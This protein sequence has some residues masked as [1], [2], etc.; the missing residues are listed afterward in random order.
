MYG[1][2][3]H[4]P[5]TNFSSTNA[6]GWNGV[7]GGSQDDGQFDMQA[8]IASFRSISTPSPWPS[9]PSHNAVPSLGSPA[10]CHTSYAGSMFPDAFAQSIPYQPYHGGYHQNFVAEVGSRFF[11]A[12]SL[13]QYVSGSL[14]SVA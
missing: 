14:S 11:C 12:G 6:P 1:T 4:W 5:Y 3:A 13:L 8:S 2:S 7:G 10:Q 9:A